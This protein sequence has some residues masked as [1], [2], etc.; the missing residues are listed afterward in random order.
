M[1][2]LIDPAWQQQEPEDQPEYWVIECAGCGNLAA[3]YDPLMVD[4]D[5]YCP[6]CEEGV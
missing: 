6:D 2:T 1:D 5:W 3:T 4:K